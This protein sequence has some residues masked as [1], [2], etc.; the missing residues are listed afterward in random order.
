MSD[1]RQ[2]WAGEIKAIISQ[3]VQ[4]GLKYIERTERRFVT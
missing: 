1:W 4:L 3:L 2:I